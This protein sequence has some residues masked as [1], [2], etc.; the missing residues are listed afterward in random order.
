M[1]KRKEKT[2]F[3][4]PDRLNRI[5]DGTKIVGDI[6]T[7]SNLRIDGEITGNIFSKSK[8]VVGETGVIL[9]NIACTEA[10]VEGN[11][12]GKLEIEGLLIL[13][14]KSKIEGDI[15]TGKLHIEEGAVFLGSC[16]MKGHSAHQKN[17]Q[18]KVI[19]SAK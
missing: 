13:R 6:I 17:T 8:V 1:L 4:S 14:E 15:Q 18:Q 16:K 3:E 19:E 9:G 10:D 2:Q 11:I 5:V 12:D 7:D